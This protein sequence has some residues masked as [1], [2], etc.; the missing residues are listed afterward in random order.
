MDDILSADDVRN[1]FVKKESIPM[2]LVVVHREVL[3]V[4][5]EWVPRVSH[6][7]DVPI[8]IKEAAPCHPDVIVMD[9]DTGVLCLCSVE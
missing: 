5:D 1:V 7:R 6:A 4:E 8:R 9:N 3:H 2:G